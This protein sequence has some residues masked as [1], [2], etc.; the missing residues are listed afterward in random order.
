MS[1]L[2]PVLLFGAAGFAFGGSY[3]LFTQRKP[4]WITTVVGV[5]GLLCL[6]AGYLYL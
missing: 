3:A 4:W 5:F 6:V 1:T 2:L